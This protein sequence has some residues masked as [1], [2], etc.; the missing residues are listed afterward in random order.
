MSITFPQHSKLKTIGMY[1]FESCRKLRTINFTNCENLTQIQ[2][3]AFS[4][5]ILL[6]D[7]ILPK[8]LKEL[9]NNAFSHC[10]S[11]QSI[12]IPDE[13]KSLGEYCFAKSGSLSSITISPNSK[14]ETIASYVFMETPLKRIFLSKN[15]RSIPRAAFLSCRTIEF[16]ECD[17][18]NTNYLAE[19]NV[20]YNKQKTFLI[21][22]PYNNLT[23]FRIPDTVEV[24]GDAFSY[25]LIEEITF[26]SVLNIIQGSAFAYSHLKSCIITDSVTMIQSGAFQRCKYLDTV[27]LGKNLTII[28]NNCFAYSNISQITIQEGVTTIG[29]YAFFQ[30]VNLKSII[31]P[32]SVKNFGGSCFPNDINLTLPPDS[33]FWFDHQNILYNSNMDKIILCLSLNERYDIPDTVIEISQA[34]FRGIQELNTINFLSD[35]NLLRIGNS[36]FRDCINLQNIN[37]PNSLES[38]GSSAFENC[39]KFNNTVFPESLNYI[40]ASSFLEC[41]SLEIHFKI[42]LL[43]I[44]NYAFQKAQSLE[45]VTF[46]SS[47]TILLNGVFS[48]CKKLKTIKLSDKTTAIFDSC[49]SNCLSLKSIE[50]PPSL[51]TLGSS[52]FS[53]SG[54]E[55]ITFLG[56][57]PIETIR[58]STFSYATKLR[59]IILSDCIREIKANAFQYTNI[60]TFR[61]P[62]QTISI[63]EYAFR[64]CSSL[65]RFII[66]ENCSLQSLGFSVFKGCRSLKAFECSHSEFFLVINGVLFDKNKTSLVCFPPA[67]ELIYFYIPE[68]VHILSPGA[69]L[70]CRNLINVLIPDHSVQTIGRY[71]FANCIS[72][73]HINL[74]ICVSEVESNA[75]ANCYKLKCGVDIQNRTQSYLNNLF[76]VAFLNKEAI[77]ECNLLTCKKQ[78][79]PMYLK[80]LTI[81]GIIDEKFL[82]L[83]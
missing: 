71:A 29:P 12:I 55:N 42:N 30:C 26:N 53:S 45:I 74:P 14:L 63:S 77:V 24:I 7:V 16:I 48:S 10:Y 51:A 57:S 3:R 41:N 72:L 44:D 40:G 66:P 2:L 20:L 70:E 37:L 18:H 38:I 82:G 62:N 67:S 73:T 43:K 52:V 33:Q 36:A 19:D 83:L 54:V 4:G 79:H 11:L 65:E 13:V 49:F 27:I 5:C 68:T 17:S 78:M 81:I 22:F 39:L 60:T 1:A 15:L 6:S 80:S 32:K 75:F 76:E 31:I 61:V 47:N 46:E 25:S 34:A 23:S 58:S 8:N 35:S 28:P 50:L 21:L 9:S 59:H 56:N 69:F 64:D